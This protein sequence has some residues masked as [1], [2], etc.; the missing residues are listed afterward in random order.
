MND[1][2]DLTNKR[3]FD[4]FP[5]VDCNDCEHWWDSSC[6]GVSKGSE[7]L[8]KDFLA[9]RRVDILKEIARLKKEV[10]RLTIY[11]YVF[12]ILFILYAS[13]NLIRR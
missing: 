13:M 5:K 8:C 4:D 1:I 6:D 12:E 10:K 7:R 3:I 2:N 11:S 9:T